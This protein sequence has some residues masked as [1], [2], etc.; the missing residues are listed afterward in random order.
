MT[1]PT[2]ETLTVHMT[3]LCEYAEEGYHQDPLGSNP[4]GADLRVYHETLT[5][6]PYREGPSVTFTLPVWDD[7]FGEWVE[8]L[9][10][11]TDGYDPD[12]EAV[13][14][15]GWWWTRLGETLGDVTL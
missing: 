9:K 15:S 4:S 1:T 7:L 8:Y 11:C 6:F 10:G 2:P 14:P 3:L 5:G 13:N 12:G